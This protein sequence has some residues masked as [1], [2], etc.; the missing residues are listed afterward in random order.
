[1]EGLHPEYHGQRGVGSMPNVE[2]VDS[3]KALALSVKKLAC[4]DRIIAPTKCI[5]RQA[6]ADYD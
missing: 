5:Q 4:Q 6:G 1:M 2:Q 3:L